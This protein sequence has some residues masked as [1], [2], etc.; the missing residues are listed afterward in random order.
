M[1]DHDGMTLGGQLHALLPP[2]SLL[3]PLLLMRCLYARL[4]SFATIRFLIE[5][6]WTSCLHGAGMLSTWNAL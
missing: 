2:S 4:C 3:D 1:G 5:L 6:A